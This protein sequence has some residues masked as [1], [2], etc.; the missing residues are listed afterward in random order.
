MSL[1]NVGTMSLMKVEII[2]VDECWDTFSESWDHVFDESW[3]N[4]VD[5]SQDKVFNER[6]DNVM[7][8]VGT[9]S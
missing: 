6:W 1:L 5:K 9:M 8:R 2:S 3:D 4:D 7:M